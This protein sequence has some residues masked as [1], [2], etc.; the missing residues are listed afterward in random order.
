VI[1]IWDIEKESCEHLPKRHFERITDVCE[2]VH[3][4]LL[5]ACSLDKKIILWD[6]ISKVPAQIIKLD[7]MSSH[8]MVYA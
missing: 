3:I 1:S 6:L 7:K 8:S 4:K 2:I 5:A